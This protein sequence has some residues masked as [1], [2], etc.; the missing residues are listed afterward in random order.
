MEQWI[1]HIQKEAE[2]GFKFMYGHQPEGVENTFQ[3]YLN[4][5]VYND[6]T[7]IV[8]TD[9]GYSAYLTFNVLSLLTTTNQMFCANLNKYLR[10]LLKKSTLISHTGAKERNHFFNE[11]FNQINLLKKRLK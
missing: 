5:V 4:E 2:L 3:L 11:Q 6:N 1:H 8:K 7:I 10:G 9:R